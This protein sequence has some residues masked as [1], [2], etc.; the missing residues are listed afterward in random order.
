MA[1]VVGKVFGIKVGFH[2]GILSTVTGIRMDDVAGVSLDLR[3][4]NA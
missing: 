4:R 3:L 2:G 1:Q